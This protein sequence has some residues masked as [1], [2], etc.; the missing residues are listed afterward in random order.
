MRKIEVIRGWM[1]MTVLAVFAVLVSKLVV[2]GGKN[3]VEAVLV[4]L[5]LGMIIGNLRLTPAFCA[6]GIK[7]YE[8][9]LILGIV[10]LG[11]AVT[12][13]ALKGAAK[14]LVVIA[15][16]MTAS[17]WLIVLA[18]RLLKLPEKLGMLLGIGTCICGGTAIAVT[19]PLIEAGEDE[20]SYAVG[21]VAIWG[22][23]AM[24][25]YP[26]IAS[27][28]SLSD[29][30][31]GIWA[32]TAIHSTPQSVGAGYMYSDA[33]GQWATMIKLCRNLFIF[34]VAV[35]V[36]V[37]YRRRRSAEAGGKVAAAKAFPW[38][39][40]GYFLMAV[41]GVAGFFSKSGV[42]NFKLAGKFLIVVAMAGIGLRTDLRG[43]RKLGFRPLLAGFMASV[44]VA[45]VSLSLASM[46]SVE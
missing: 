4:A 46:M 19:S 43:L 10:L 34:P 9:L 42:A 25:A 8:K 20:T 18:A 2:V 17:F 26:L 41:L 22:L 7:A 24:I 44:V 16:T 5:I 40:L 12:L 6:A 29:Q 30:V 31:F 21:T 13:G 36:S 38:F 1:L 45:I 3:P 37:W 11:S 14:A 23:L 15:V 32:G 35:A 39:L 28:L 27:V 33:A